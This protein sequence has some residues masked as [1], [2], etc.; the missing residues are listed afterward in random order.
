MLWCTVSTT[1][2][3]YVELMSSDAPIRSDRD[4]ADLVAACH[5]R[6]SNLLMLHQAALH[7]E[8]FDLKSGLAGTLLQ[9]LVNNR[10][11]GVL[12]APDDS[13]YRGKRFEELV[14]ESN[15]GDQFGVFAGRG[16]AEA[17]LLR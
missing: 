4:A 13:V 5:E 9:K 8:F 6:E 1:G 10:I 17:W 15:R 3:G 7:A 12:V 2:G 14:S 16:A 11:R